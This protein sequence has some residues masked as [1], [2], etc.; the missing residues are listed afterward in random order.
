[1]SHWKVL[2]SKVLFQ[3]PFM[4]LRADRC[5]LPDQRIM[6]KYYVVD[7]P[8]WVQT[9]AITTDNKL[10]MVKQYRHAAGEFFLEL[11]GGSVEPGSEESI[12]MAALRELEEETGYTSEKV[13]YLGYFYPNPALQSNKNHIFLAHSCKKSSE[14]NLDPFEELEVELWDIDLVFKSLK[15]GEI[16]HSLMAAGLNLVRA[17][18]ESVR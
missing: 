3:T 9:A 1:M 7:F 6:P 4:K 11:P 8:D 10:V 15:K 18:L 16:K 12:Q 13:E 17:K 14:L 5:E 2:D